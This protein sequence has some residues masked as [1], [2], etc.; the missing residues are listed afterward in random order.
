M[1]RITNIVMGFHMNKASETIA[2]AK[3]FNFSLTMLLNASMNIGSHANIKCAITFIGYD[4]DPTAHG[5]LLP[6]FWM[7]RATA[8][9][10]GY[11]KTIIQH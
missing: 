6:P 4:I 11:N 7:P 1:D 10:D 5:N 9:H 3:P 8:G 2:L